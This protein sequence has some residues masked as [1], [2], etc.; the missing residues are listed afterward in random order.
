MVLAREFEAFYLMFKQM[1]E[2]LPWL[3]EVMSLRLVW[4]V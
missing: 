2:V 3:A 1:E 4:E